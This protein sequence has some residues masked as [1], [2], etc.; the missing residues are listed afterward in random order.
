MDYPGGPNVPNALVLRVL[1]KE[2]EGREVN[3]IVI[4]PEK[5]SVSHYW[6]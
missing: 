4:Q 2:E 1:Y 5:D 3:A 6:L